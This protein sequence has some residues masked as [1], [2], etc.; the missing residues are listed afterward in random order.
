[1]MDDG[2]MAMLEA[3]VTSIPEASSSC[4]QNY[5]GQIVVE[6]DISVIAAFANHFQVTIIF[7]Y[8]V[9]N[10]FNSHSVKSEIFRQ[11]GTL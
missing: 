11:V 2:L 10:A 3:T 8:A 9:A 4:A 1:M 6:V 5:G 7:I